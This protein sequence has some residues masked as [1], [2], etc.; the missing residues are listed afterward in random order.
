MTCNNVEPLTADNRAS[1]TEIVCNG[2]DLDDGGTATTQQILA[3]TLGTVDGTADG[4]EV[5][6]DASGNGNPEGGELITHRAAA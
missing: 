5:A 6:H 4:N 3:A 2:Y 1:D